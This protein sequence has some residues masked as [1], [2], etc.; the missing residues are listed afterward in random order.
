MSG[1]IVRQLLARLFDG[2]HCNSRATPTLLHDKYLLSVDGQKGLW[3]EK[4]ASVPAVFL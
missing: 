3:S 4:T 1:T 2:T